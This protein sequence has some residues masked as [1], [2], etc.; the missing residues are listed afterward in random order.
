[1]QITEFL[2]DKFA[3]L[4]LGVVISIC[5][6][7]TTWYSSVSEKVIQEFWTDNKSISEFDSLTFHI[8]TIRWVEGIRLFNSKYYLIDNFCFKNKLNKYFHQ[9]DFRVGETIS[10]NRIREELYIINE[11][12][13]VDTLI[14]QGCL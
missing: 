9:R 7:V 13:S 6:I 12:N 1:M 5:V 10:Y 14:Q 3:L 8:E 11:K 2:K 4:V